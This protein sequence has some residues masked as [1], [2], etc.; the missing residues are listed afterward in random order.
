VPDTHQR[1]VL[2]ELEERG[3]PPIIRA[4][5]EDDVLGICAGLW[6]GGER[7]VGLVQQLGLFASVNALRGITHDLDIPLAILA[8]MYGRE[9]D[10]PVERSPKSS[11]SLCR[12]VLDALGVAS[13]LVE[14]PD[15]AEL[16]APSLGA[17]FESRCSHVVL[18]GAPTE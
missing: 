13:V 14:T 4:A 5:T 15:D 9:L 11:V 6:I 16:I 2:A 7:P 17:A 10:L 8:G 12:P 1:T 18:L 3:D